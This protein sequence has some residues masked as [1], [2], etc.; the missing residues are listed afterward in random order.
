MTCHDIVWYDN[1]ANHIISSIFNIIL[2]LLIL[3]SVLFILQIGIFAVF[4]IL[5]LARQQFQTLFL[6]S[7]VI[8]ISTEPLSLSLFQKY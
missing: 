3:F 6:K 5:I 2:K 1:M 8:L 7:T 4:D